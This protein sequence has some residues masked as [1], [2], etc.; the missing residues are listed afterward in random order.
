[1]PEGKLRRRRVLGMLGVTGATGLAG[2]GNQ[3]GDSPGQNT[4]NTDS[5]GETPADTPDDDLGTETPTERGLQIV[6]FSTDE[7]AV[8]ETDDVT[9]T[10]SVANNTDETVAANFRIRAGDTE[11]RSVSRRIPPEETETVSVHQ[12]LLRVGEH[13]FE[14]TVERDGSPVTSAQTGVTVEQ[15]HTSFVEATGTDFT[16]DGE[17]FYAAG[18]HGN[19]SLSVGVSTPLTTSIGRS[20]TMP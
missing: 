20:C 10:L 19:S 13:Q 5:D 1:M 16:I 15:L 17:T 8:R 14:A 12:E 4:Q 9:L 2:C 6:A 11:L 18:T 7:S 3:S